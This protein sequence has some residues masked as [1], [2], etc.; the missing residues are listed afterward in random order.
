MYP[1][2][3]ILHKQT[4]LK[5]FAETFPIY[6]LDMSLFYT[7]LLNILGMEYKKQNISRA[8]G[9]ASQCY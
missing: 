2:G 6:E 9:A 4:S 5:Y 7:F 1:W 3:L 8:V